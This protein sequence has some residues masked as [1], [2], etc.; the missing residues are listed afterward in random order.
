[1]KKPRHS[2][3]TTPPVTTCVLEM[4]RTDWMAELGLAPRKRVLG[5]WMR[6]HRFWKKVWK[7]E[8]GLTAINMDLSTN[9]TDDRLVGGSRSGGKLVLLS[10]FRCEAF[11]YG[12]VMFWDLK[13]SL[14]SS[15]PTL[16]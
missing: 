5:F 13:I 3:S 11:T 12:G 8:T 1:M 15:R 7:V 9:R 6:V 4:F 14:D 2:A 10:L 16:E